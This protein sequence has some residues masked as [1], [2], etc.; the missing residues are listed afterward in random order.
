MLRLLNTSHGSGLSVLQVCPT[1]RGSVA[2]EAEK[3]VVFMAAMWSLVRDGIIVPGRP[4]G[5]SYYNHTTADVLGF[6]SF[7]V[8][9]FG[10]QVLSS[11]DVIHPYE[12]NAYMKNARQRLGEADEVIFTYL[13]ESRH[14]FTDGNQLSAS[15]MLGVSSEMLMKWLLDR[16]IGHLPA[17]KQIEYRKTKAQLWKRTDRLFDTFIS[18]IKLHLEP[19][20]FP[21]DLRFQIDAHLDQVQTLLRV[22]RDDV[23]H[24]RPERADAQIVSA[25]LELYLPLLSIVRELVVNLK[26]KPCVL[27]EESTTART[28]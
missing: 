1:I 12:A 21:R 2:Y 5:I 8:T 18:A 6:P 20:G 11:N 4:A 23:G 16:F 17:Q 25:S 13:A 14:S 24:G 27:Y 26:S 15:I 3:D 28:V 9:P 19:D 7:T 10:R 22:T